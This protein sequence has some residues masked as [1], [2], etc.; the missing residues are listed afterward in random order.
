MNICGKIHQ[1]NKRH[2][3]F[4][5]RKKTIWRRDQRQDQNTTK[6]EQFH[7]K[8]EALVIC[9]FLARFLCNLAAEDACLRMKIT[10]GVVLIRSLVFHIC[11]SECSR[12]GSGV[13]PYLWVQE[14]L[15]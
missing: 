13:R 15:V 8:C 6:H 2:L 10:V 7:W 9:N 3:Y 5:K 12:N 1:S 11:V 4:T 14:K